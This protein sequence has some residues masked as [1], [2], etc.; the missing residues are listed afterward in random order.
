M[1]F[2]RVNSKASETER[3]KS[4]ITVYVVKENYVMDLDS[5]KRVVKEGDWRARGIQESIIIR[6]NLQKINRMKAG[7]SSLTCMMT[8][9]DHMTF[10]LT[11]DSHRGNGGGGV[12]RGG[13]YWVQ[14]VI[15]SFPACS[16]CWSIQIVI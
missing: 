9:L 7:T 8:F 6:K 10:F 11:P 12:G 3:P 16:C 15:L 2:A 1:L 4:A 14:P 5:N 13:M